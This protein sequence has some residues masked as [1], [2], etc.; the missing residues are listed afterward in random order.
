MNEVR[1]TRGRS[2]FP[3]FGK[4]TLRAFHLVEMIEFSVH[5]YVTHKKKGIIKKLRKVLNS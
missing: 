4:E 2:K 3:L 5:M 1:L